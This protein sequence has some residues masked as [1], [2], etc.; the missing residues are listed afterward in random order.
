MVFK[1]PAGFQRV[2]FIVMN[3]AIGILVSIALTVLIMQQPLTVMGIGISTLT[4]FFIGYAVSDL[5]PAMAWG[6]AL[7][8]KMG[9]KGGIGAH[10]VSSAVLAF[11]MGTFILLFMA[12][13][14][15]FPVAGFEGAAGFFAGAY[16]LVLAVAYA[17]ILIFLPVA[18][19]IAGAVSGFNPAQA[20]Q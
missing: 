17:A 16:L 7:A 18:M 2:I 10:F 11:F 5:V 9:L 13:I 12:F 19:K 1:G 14:N 8:Q 6:Q 15:V 20:A 3:V 4:S